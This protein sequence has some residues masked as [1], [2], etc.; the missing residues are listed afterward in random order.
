MSIS[1]EEATRRVAVNRHAS[2]H[3]DRGRVGKS[4]IYYPNLTLP[5]T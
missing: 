3:M 5:L 1:A 2:H 4:N